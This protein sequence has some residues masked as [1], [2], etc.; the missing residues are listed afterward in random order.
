MSVKASFDGAGRISEFVGQFIS[1]ID[2]I[3]YLAL[4]P[5]LITTLLSYRIEYTEGKN[6]LPAAVALIAVVILELAGH[7]TLVNTPYASLYNYPRFIDRSIREFGLSRFLIQDFRS[8]HSDETTLL[9]PESSADPVESTESPESAESEDTRRNHI[10]DASWEEIMNADDNADRKKIDQYLMSRTMTEY[11]DH[12]GMFQD[13]NVVYVM[14]E[15]FDYMAIDPQLTPTLYK[16]KEEGWDFTHHYTPKFSC[17]TGESEFVSEISLVPMSDVCTPNQWAAN[18]WQNSIF[19]LFEHAGYYTSAYHNWIDEYYDRR[20]LYSHSGCEA[21]LNYD[22]LNYTRLWGWQSDL[23]MMELTI[24]YWINQDHFFSLYVTTSTHFPYDQGSELGNRYLNEVS[25]VHPDYPLLVQRYI[26]KAIELDKSME[27]LLKQLEDAGK[28][29][30]TLIVLFA[31]HHPLETP[32]Q[33]LA[34]YGGQEADRLNGFDEDR[35]PMIFYTP[36]MTPTKQDRINSTFD[37]LPTVANLIGLDYEPRIYVGHDYFD[38]ESKLVIFPNGSWI[39]DN[40]SYYASDD[41]HDDTLS[42]EE[43]ESRNLEV[44]NLFTISRMIYDSDYFHFRPTVP[45]PGER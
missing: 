31:D 27:Y 38:P 22:D 35:T 7:F 2:P 18:D 32:L 26:S 36:S 13:Y 42:E 4:I 23:E 20:I 40:G 34:D 30:H 10:S 29:D 41:T 6:M 16:M 39:T 37:I 8:I 21:Y 5:P 44:Q 9:V 25:A 19:N 11:N 12:T 45:F 28:L 24:P 43:I 14:I 3:Y 15:A 33:I 17:A 1:L